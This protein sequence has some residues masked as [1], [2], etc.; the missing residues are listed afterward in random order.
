M[1]ASGSSEES[2]PHS[3]SPSATGRS[4]AF[5]S[6]SSQDQDWANRVCAFLEAVGFPC[7]IAPRDILPASEYGTSILHAIE[8]SRLMVLIFS[9]Q[10]NQSAQVRRE[11]ERA[12]SKGLV[13]VPCRVEDARPKGVLEYALGNTHW[14]DLSA[15]PVDQQLQQ[16]ADVVSQSGLQQP[17]QTPY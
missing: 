11:V 4:K 3:M 10:A 17:P 7:W 6:Y 8:T 14:L 16:L 15:C 13:I 12:V 5:I 2:Q 9:E 1:T